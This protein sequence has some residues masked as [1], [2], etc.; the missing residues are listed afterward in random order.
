[1]RLQVEVRVNGNVVRWQEGRV[2]VDLANRQRK[3]EERPVVLQRQGHDHFPYDLDLSAWAELADRKHVDAAHRLFVQ[4]RELA[5]VRCV[6]VSGARRLA[7]Q[8]NRMEPASADDGG[9]AGQ[10]RL[11]GGWHRE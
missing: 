2:A 10:H 4:D 3:P 9:Q 5:T 11:E 8:G 6:L 7:S 1:M